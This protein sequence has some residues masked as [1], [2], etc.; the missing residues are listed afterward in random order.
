M[1][2]PAPNEPQDAAN[3]DEDGQFDSLMSSYLD[4]VKELA[5]GQL[6]KAR[7]VA[8]RKDYV[9]LD[10]GDKAEGIVEIKEF[11]DFRG[12][13]KISVGD[14]VDVVLQGRDP[15]TGQI[16]VSYRQAKQ[17][18][19]WD[20]VVEAFEKNQPLHGHVSRALAK[21]VMV[22]AGIPCF[23]PASQCDIGHVDDLATLV[24]Q[25]VDVYVIDLDKA[26]HRAVVS[27]RKLLSE[28]VKKKREETLKTLEEGT[29]VSG[30]VKNIVDFGVFVD[31]GGVDGLVPREEI[32]WE[33]NVE[34]AEALKVNY[35]YKFK[36]LTV[37][38]E[39][40]RVSLSRRQLKPDPWLKI[41]QDYPKD[42]NVKGVVTNM[43]RNCAYVRLEDGIEGRIH[44]NN[45]SWN[46]SIN[47]PQDVLKE[48]DTVRA[49]VLDYDREK[50]LLDLGLKQ[51]S[52]DPWL[53][54][55][56]KYPINSRQKVKILETVPYGAFVQLDDNTKGLIHV[57]D[58]SYDRSFKDPKNL[59]KVGD[60]IEAVV[61]KLDMDARRI[62]LG[63]KQLE[64]DP[65]EAYVRAH[66]VNSIVTGKVKGVTKFGAFVELAPHVEGL[67]HKTQWSRDKVE[68]IEG[69][70]KEGE[71][72][73]AKIIKIEK[74]DKKVSL[75]RRAHLH[76][77]ERREIDAYARQNPKDATTSLGSLLKNLKINVN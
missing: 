66:P 64:Q 15:E 36:V 1:N 67:L 74:K 49:V 57:S 45:L 20:H 65:F 34:A 39:R 76:D 48:N 2:T 28:E 51:I 73:T 25:E 13:V 52:V 62:N 41:E 55:E 42:L 10:V 31:L 72:V 21:G 44:R 43:T 5:Y 33:K 8:V 46:M 71:E 18:A 56:Q 37:D 47:K 61:L 59:V 17:R 54:I 77:E 69:L 26:K 70:V 58:M 9:L 35:N 60:E 24:G 68:T 40:G 29:T 27:R 63:I 14:E 23:M 53:E 4:S 19:N 75:S 32:A 3:P 12:N 22:E 50:R 16:L 11:E 30:K 7:V 38:R 6:T